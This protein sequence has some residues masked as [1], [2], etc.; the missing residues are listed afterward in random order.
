MGGSPIT[1]IWATQLRSEGLMTMPT[2]I[3][4]DLGDTLLDLRGLVP[5]MERQVG[6]HFP[7]LRSYA[8]KIAFDW[9][10]KTIELIREAQGH[11][12]RPG[13][14][15]SATALCAAMTQGGSEVDF[16]TALDLVRSAWGNYVKRAR[17]YDDVTPGLLTA[18]HRRM[19]ITGIV[20]DS[21]ASIMEPL[22]ARLNLREF[23]DVIVL[24]ES[25]GAYKPNP[26]IFLETLRESRGTAG[27]S[28]FV[29]D[30]TVDLSGA[31]A[32]GMGTIWIRR[33]SSPEDA[34]RFSPTR[35]IA[36]LAELPQVLDQW[37]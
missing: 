6:S 14:E 12:F 28:L 37:H 31:A 36:S 18:L 24:S 15:I 32:V 7:K 21:D 29:S 8:R 13:T 20:T 3:F 26:R 23:F 27:T 30:S 11:A 5:E 33:R 16:R 17:F 35:T 4:F 34:G 22:I 1:Y 9:V 19:K 10:R 25:V 2:H